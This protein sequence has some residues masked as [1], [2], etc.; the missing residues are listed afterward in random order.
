MTKMH[1]PSGSRVP[2]LNCHGNI[3]LPGDECAFAFRVGDALFLTKYPKQF[4]SHEQVLRVL[5]LWGFLYE[6]INEQVSDVLKTI[7]ENFRNALNGIACQV[8]GFSSKL[9]HPFSLDFQNAQGVKQCPDIERPTCVSTEELASAGWSLFWLLDAQTLKTFY[10]VPD[11]LDAVELMLP[12]GESSANISTV[13]A[14]L[15]SNALEHGILQLDSK[16]KATSEGMLD[17]YTKREQRLQNLTDA[18]LAISLSH[19][20]DTANSG[21]FNLELEDSGNGFDVNASMARMSPQTAVKGQYY[22]RGLTLLKSLCSSIHFENNG[23]LVKATYLY[24]S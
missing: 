23:T 1:A 10:P 2:C 24:P 6:N 22:G 19:S 9:A 8:F 7:D 14:E 11:M 15:T 12:A 18:R 3:D 4:D 13:L 16:L 20:R 17:Y 21:C 5:A